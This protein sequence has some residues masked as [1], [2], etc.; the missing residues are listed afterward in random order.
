MWDASSAA[1]L[2][3]QL[4]AVYCNKLYIWHMPPNAVQRALHVHARVLYLYYSKMNRTHFSA[5]SW[6]AYRQLPRLGARQRLAVFSRLAMEKVARSNVH[7][8][9][10]SFDVERRHDR[11]ALLRSWTTVG[12][13]EKRGNPVTSPTVRGYLP[14]VQ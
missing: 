9:R 12:F 2:D 13:A 8:E 4:G 5:L 7:K 14:F 3:L 1:V 6:R 10:K 11:T